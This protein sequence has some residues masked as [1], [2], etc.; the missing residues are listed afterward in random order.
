MFRQE[1]ADV[2]PL[3]PNGQG[4]SSKQS[5]RKLYILLAGTATIAII[6]TA[7]LVT[8]WSPG[9]DYNVQEHMVYQITN[10]GTSLIPGTTT[11]SYNSTHTIDVIGSNSENLS[12]KQKMTL[13]PNLL[14][15]LLNLPIINV[16]KATFYTNFIAPGAPLIFSSSNQTA[17]VST[18]SA[19][20]SVKV[21]DVWTVPVNTG[22]TS[23]G[24]TGEVKLTFAEIQDLTIPAGSFKTMR[25]EITSNTLSIHSDGT[26]IIHISPGTTLKLNGTS[27]IEPGTCLLVKTDLTQL[28]T[29]NLPGINSG[30]T[31]YTE[32]TLVDYAKS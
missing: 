29:T 8:S 7:L 9:T 30:S 6:A 3:Q 22:N 5:R 20:Q 23:L 11:T 15:N 21:G 26:S 2:P 10:I 17:I 27:Y 19:L 32:K 18:Y 25:I 14:G 1:H 31:L 12:L 24:V 16:S 28:M 4:T 13:T